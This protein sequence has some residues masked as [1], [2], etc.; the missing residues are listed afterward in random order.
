MTHHDIYRSHAYLQ[1][2]PTIGMFCE[3][4]ILQPASQVLRTGPSRYGMRGSWAAAGCSRSTLLRCTPR[5]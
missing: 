3:N 4:A 2:K 1:G 5:R